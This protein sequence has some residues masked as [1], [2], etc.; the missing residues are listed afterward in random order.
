MLIEQYAFE[1]EANITKTPI[2]ISHR[3]QVTVLSPST[4][5]VEAFLIFQDG[6]KLSIFEFLKVVNDKVIRE[7]Y[8]YHYMDSKNNLIFRYDNAPHHKSIDTFPD[9]KHVRDQVLDSTG[10][11][12][13]EVLKEIE[14]IVLSIPSI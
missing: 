10:P 9:H 1:L 13:K 3:F 14:K 11:I 2:L 8:R 4:G 7:K 12:V 5:F 6:S